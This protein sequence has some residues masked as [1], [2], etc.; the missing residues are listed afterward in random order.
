MIPESNLPRA[1]N[2]IVRSRII[3]T[4]ELLAH[5]SIEKLKCRLELTASTPSWLILHA[6]TPKQLFVSSFSFG[7]QQISCVH[8]LSLYLS[9]DTSNLSKDRV[10][11]FSPIHTNVGVLFMGPCYSTRHTWI[12]SS[13]HE[14][15]RDSD[16]SNDETS[17][18]S[19]ESECA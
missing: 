18:S 6:F 8:L 14:T 2:N 3:F 1:A 16:Y 12:M 4:V 11:V 13:P 7:V 9:C 5:G 19:D 17:Y 10:L 15:G